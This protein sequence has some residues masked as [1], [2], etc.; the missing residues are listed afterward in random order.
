[1]FG[2]L[3]SPFWQ[4]ALSLLAISVGNRNI[5]TVSLSYEFVFS[6][7]VALQH[8]CSYRPCLTEL[9]VP[10]VPGLDPGSGRPAGGCCCLT[11][12]VDIPEKKICL[13]CKP[14]FLLC[15]T[16]FV[17]FTHGFLDEKISVPE[18]KDFLHSLAF[19]HFTECHDIN[20]ARPFAH[21]Q[22]CFNSTRPCSFD[23]K[24]RVEHRNA[25]QNTTTKK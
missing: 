18:L 1:M 15:W 6:Q 2:R 11:M 16:P 12:L 13:S 20:E 8:C 19:E 17:V 25:G 3:T 23:D 21:N 7:V 24:P 14:S 4:E 22:L 5:W 9:A 10:D